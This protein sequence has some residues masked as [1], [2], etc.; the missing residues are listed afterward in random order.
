MRSYDLKA[1]R[2][3]G[4]IKDGRG[5]GSHPS[6]L[7]GHQKDKGDLM[8]SPNIPQLPQS[9]NNP[10]PNKIPDSLDV[11]RTGAQACETLWGIMDAMGISPTSDPLASMSDLIFSGNEIRVRLRRM[12]KQDLVEFLAAIEIALRL[13]H[14]SP[15]KLERAAKI[16]DAWQLIISARGIVTADKFLKLLELI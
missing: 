1:T 16:L 2:Q 4:R 9:G 15:D 14:T 13:A 11:I 3:N 5:N 7:P 6:P 12:H 10:D 8:D